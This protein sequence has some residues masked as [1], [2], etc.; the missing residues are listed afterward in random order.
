MSKAVTTLPRS[1]PPLGAR[2]N[3]SKVQNSGESLQAT[4]T[5]ED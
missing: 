5:E 3:H 1:A 4:L 2:G